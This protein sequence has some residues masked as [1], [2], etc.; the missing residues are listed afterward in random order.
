MSARRSDIYRVT[1]A[2][3]AATHDALARRAMDAACRA[4][5]PEALGA[6]ERLKSIAPASIAL[7]LAVTGAS[8]PI[9]S[10]ARA[11][12]RQP[13]DVRKILSRIE[14]RRDCPIVEAFLDALTP[15]MCFS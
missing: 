1:R 15:E 9:K 5:A 2:H 8:V 12:G 13:C 4:L 6:I 10:A 3:A 11:A 14:D 7:Y